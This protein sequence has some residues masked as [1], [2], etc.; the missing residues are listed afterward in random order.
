MSELGLKSYVAK[1]VPVQAIQITA[2]NMSQVAKWCGGELRSGRHGAEEYKYIKVAVFRAANERQTQGRVGD[3]VIQRGTSF[4]VYNDLAFRNNYM[5]D[6]KGIPLTKTDDETV[7]DGSVFNGMV[8]ELTTGREVTL[9]VPNHET[10][11]S[12]PPAGVPMRGNGGAPNT[13]MFERP[14]FVEP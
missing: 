7:M 5:D 8:Q 13:G 11:F 10:Q 14:A 9:N 1:P 2:Q 6:P 3:W 12:T 4:K